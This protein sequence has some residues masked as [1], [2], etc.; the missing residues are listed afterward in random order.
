MRLVWS[1]VWWVEHPIVNRGDGGSISPAAVSNLGK[2]VLSAL[3]EE[4]VKAVSLPGEV[5]YST[6][7]AIVQP[8]VDS[9]SDSLYL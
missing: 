2:F 4:T 9:K 3:S 7:G 5:D 6:Q 1:G 8:V